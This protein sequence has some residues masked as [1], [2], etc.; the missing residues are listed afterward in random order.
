MRKTTRMT[1]KKGSRRSRSVFLNIPFDNGYETRYVALIA[2]LVG[3]G[4]TPRSALEVRSSDVRLSRLFNLLKSCGSSIH[5]LSRVQLSSTKPHCPRFN[6]PFEAGLATALSL[7]KKNHKFF[8]FESKPH[9]L[10]K[11]L[12]DLNGIDP[13]IHWGT[14]K[15]TLSAVTDV[16][17]GPGRQ[18]DVI[19]LLCLYKVLRVL[20]K[21]IKKDYNGLYRPSSFR[22]LVYGC[23]MIVE[24]LNL[25]PS[26]S[27]RSITA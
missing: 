7:S 9:R 13:S 27:R 8:I 20:S 16:F 26:A 14:V 19:T 22:H 23:Q 6:M 25:V 10:Q 21:K 5:D 2:G 3:L 15:G 11:S 24:K 12:S 17:Y 4:M 1:E 18:Y